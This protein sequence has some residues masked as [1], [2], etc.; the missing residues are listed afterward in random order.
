MNPAN[1]R[2]IE[3]AT[4]MDFL[5][6]SDSDLL[7]EQMNLYAKDFQ[8]IFAKY[9][10]ALGRLKS[11]RTFHSNHSW[12]SLYSNINADCPRLLNMRDLENRIQSELAL[13]EPKEQLCFIASV[14][15]NFFRS[16]QSAGMHLPSRIKLNQLVG[17]RLLKSIRGCD[18]VAQLSLG[19]F[20]IW[21]GDNESE[22]EVIEVLDRVRNFISRSYEIEE[23]TVKLYALTFYLRVIEK[24]IDLPEYVRRVFGVTFGE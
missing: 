19:N 21:L 17:N 3:K 23:E 24:D 8:G 10:E 6:D 7:I 2:N 11:L 4:Q 20:V 15:I 5:G 18:C 22:S 1:K 12:I 16:E 13:S 9:Q 14:T